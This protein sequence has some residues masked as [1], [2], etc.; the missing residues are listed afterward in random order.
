M[1]R[2]RLGRRLRK[3]TQ[4]SRK[5]ASW[6]SPNGVIYLLLHLVVALLGGILVLQG[7]TVL[8]AIGTSMIAAGTAGWVIYVYVQLS[9]RTA[10]RL[11]LITEFGLLEAFPS[12][13]ATI[14]GKY[15]ERLERAHSAI[16]VLGFGL[17]ALRQD[18]S[19][20]FEGWVSKASVRILLIDP[21]APESGKSYADQRDEEEGNPIGTI[22]RDVQS[23]LDQTVELRTMHP[24]RFQIR[25]YQCMPSI[26]IFRVDDIAFWGP[27]LL[28]RQSRNTSTMIVR[29]GILFDQLLEH[30]EA[31]WNEGSRP[32]PLDQQV[33]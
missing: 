25:L 10:N 24:E 29:R 26:N 18:Y 27:Y 33:Q 6:L 30:F 3:R 7:G 1:K 19:T 23:F 14:R 20:Q 21:E 4:R 28:R 12:R 17:Q 31:L 13:A 8:T 15:D 32:A 5:L 11:D 9:E 22:T 16:D 2:R